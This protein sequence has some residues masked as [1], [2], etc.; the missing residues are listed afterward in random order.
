MEIGRIM[1]MMGKDQSVV[2]FELDETYD[3]I[4]T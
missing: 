4:Y 2:S 1:I 3:S